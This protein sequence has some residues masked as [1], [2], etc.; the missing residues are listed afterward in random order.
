MVICCGENH[1]ISFYLNFFSLIEVTGNTLKY[2]IA[3]KLVFLRD[4]AFRFCEFE[5][6]GKCTSVGERKDIN[7]S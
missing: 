4:M 6:G 1:H 2:F 7:Y 3:L 5:S